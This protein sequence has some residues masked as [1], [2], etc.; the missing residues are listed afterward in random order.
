MGRS[1]LRLISLTLAASL[2]APLVIYVGSQTMS[3]SGHLV[4]GPRLAITIALLM[5]VAVALQPLLRRLAPI[6]DRVA[7][8][9]VTFLDSIPDG[10]AKLAIFASA[11]LSLFLELAVIRW[12][13]TIFEV[14]AFYKN[15]TLLACFAGLGLGYAMARRTL[16][17]LFLSPVLLGWQ[18]ALLSGMR[19]G[20]AEWNR[21]SLQM[22][23]FSEQLNVGLPVVDKFYQGLPVFFLLAIVFVITVLAFIPI[24]QLC[25]RLMER[26]D[27][28]S[29]YGFNLLGSIAGVLLMFL[30]SA[31]WTPPVIWF[32]L[33]FVALMLFYERRLSLLLFAGA[34]SLLALV[35]LAWPAEPSWQRIYSPYQLLEV[36]HDYRGLMVIR[37][38][39]EYY[40]R[41]HDLEATGDPS[42][43][44]QSIRRY[45]ELPYRFF[46]RSPADVAI[47]GAGSGNDVTAA[48]LSGAKRVDAVEIDPAI[49]MEGRYAHPNHPYSNPRVHAVLDDARSFLRNTNQRYDMI[50]YGLLDSHTLLTQ[51]SSV[52]LDSFVYTVEGLREARAR[53]KPGGVI[54]LSFSVMNHQ[55]GRKIYLMLQDAFGGWPPVC[56]M[57]GY[58]GAIVFLE[59]NDRQ[60]TIPARLI[61]QTGF[62]DG[63]HYFADPTIQADVSTD[64]WPFFYMPRRVYPVSYAIMVGLVLALS[65]GIFWKFLD[66]KPQFG[67]APFF[68]LGAGFMLIETKGI[69]ELGLVFGNT[70]QVM[71]IVIIAILAMAFLANCAVQYFDLQNWAIPYLLLFAT[72]GMGWLVV[73]MGGL[74]S[75]FVGR[76][77]MAIVLT[78]PMFFS[79]IVFSTLLRSR[80][81]VSGILAMNLLGAMCGGLLEYNSMYFGFQFLY[82]VAAGLY[83]LA[84]IWEL[85]QPKWQLAA[86]LEPK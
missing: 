6:F 33:A 41:V 22:L 77:G 71:G 8:R 24:G 55:L 57:A 69:T 45:Y 9:Q 60:L 46:G 3:H 82:L 29:A 7:A 67:H 2:L 84:F 14:F 80:G 42:P 49:L 39:G 20:L 85:A 78:C 65:A 34:A 86:V 25:G 51:G 52:R 16:V 54:S 23:P 32:L 64:D 31:F 5:I 68:L 40:Q 75:N 43:G 72:L 56:I 44:D 4:I 73:R 1:Y 58:D 76:I 27:N 17:A 83:F 11:A 21:T 35:I 81:A 18:F 30:V 12:Q 15:F 59:A 70:W 10:Y 48:L 38:A 63:T 26:R 28:L 36:G 37:A 66:E 79:G 13:G 19:Y 53:L 62:E 47:V 50:V 74:P 61:Q